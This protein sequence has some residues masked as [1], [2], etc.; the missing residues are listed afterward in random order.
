M[1]GLFRCDFE[2]GAGRGWT[3]TEEGAPRE[4]HRGEG[5]GTAPAGTAA[6]T[7]PAK[8][9]DTQGVRAGRQRTR[10]PEEGVAINV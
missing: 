1:L 5:S 2:F 3:E 7:P 4:P 10:V 8:S 9:Q 6:L